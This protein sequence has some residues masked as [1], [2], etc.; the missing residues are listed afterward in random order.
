LKEYFPKFCAK[1]SHRILDTSSL[2]LAHEIRNKKF[3]NKVRK[4]EPQHRA[5]TD[6]QTSL[7]FARKYYG[8]KRRW[9]EGTTNMGLM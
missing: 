2:I 9:R 6:I 8:K 1:F 5:E 4:L 7:N 3:K